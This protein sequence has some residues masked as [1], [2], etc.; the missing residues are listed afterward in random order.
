[1]LPLKIFPE[2][3]SLPSLTMGVARVIRKLDKLTWFI[4]FISWFVRFIPKMPCL[5]KAAFLHTFPKTYNSVAISSVRCR[6]WNSEG[7]T[8]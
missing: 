3:V 2:G 7:E 6:T 8:A 5:A 4:S 1:M